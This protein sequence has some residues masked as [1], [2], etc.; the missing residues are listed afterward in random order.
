M[1]SEVYVNDHQLRRWL[2]FPKPHLSLGRTVFHLAL[3]ILSYRCFIDSYRAHE[4]P[5]RPEVLTP[6]SFS[7]FRILPKQHFRGGALYP[8]HHLCGRVFWWHGNTEMH[9]IDAYFAFDYYYLHPFAYLANQL[10]EPL[11]Y[12]PFQHAKTIL[13]NPHKVVFYLI[14]RMG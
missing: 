3:D 2:L 11:A 13:W 6:V 14:Y 9:M 10:L 5:S 7:Q 12:L 4:V 8:L 1:T